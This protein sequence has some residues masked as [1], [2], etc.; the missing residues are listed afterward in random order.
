MVPAWNGLTPMRC[1]LQEPLGCGGD[2]ERADLIGFKPE[3]F[4]QVPLGRNSFP[5]ITNCEW[6]KGDAQNRELLN[7]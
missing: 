1:F 6:N 7:S 5:S 4:L 2:C 3:V